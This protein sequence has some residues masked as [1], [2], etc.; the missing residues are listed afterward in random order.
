MAALVA[1]MGLY[2]AALGYVVA[3]WLPATGARALAARVPAAWLLIEW[4]RGWFLSGFLV[5]VARVFP[6]RHVACRLRA[7]R[8]GVWHQR[9]AVG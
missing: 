6:D 1:I 7:D 8:R 2:H 9:G 4:W 5:A 3:R